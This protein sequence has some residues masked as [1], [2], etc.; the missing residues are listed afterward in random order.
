MWKTVA[1]EVAVMYV[2]HTH[3]ALEELLILRQAAFLSQG[4]AASSVHQHMWEE[5]SRP[6][7]SV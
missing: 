1:L 7:Q 6:S 5:L 2:Y 3:T 4:C